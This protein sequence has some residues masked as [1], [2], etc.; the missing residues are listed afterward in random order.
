MKKKYK[1]PQED[2]W[3]GEFG[4]AYTER[5]S[6]AKLIA[7]NIALFSKVLSHTNGIN[8]I[9]EL[10]ANRGLNLL[11]LKQLLPDASFYGVEINH[12]A[13]NELKK[14]GFIKVSNTSILEYKPA[15]T[16]SLVLIKGVLIH[17]NPNVLGQ[18]YDLMVKASSRY[19][20]IAEYYNSTPVTVDYR[21]YSERLFK[22]DF[23]GELM[24]RHPTLRLIEYGFAYSGDPVFP[25]G[26]ITW[27]LMEK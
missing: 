27:F 13:A 11:A 17:L 22:R 9:L 3:A 12:K 18:V 5:N 25:Q 24:A 8:S 15:A 14:H 6:D 26:D 23:A 2:F 21:G 10:G 7:S 20:C 1:T 4:D 16:T 19:V